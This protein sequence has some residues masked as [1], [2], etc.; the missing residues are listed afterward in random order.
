MIMRF[1]DNF[2]AGG[3]NGEEGDR[4]NEDGEAE[5]V[6]CVDE[7]RCAEDKQKTAA[8]ARKLKRTERATYQKAASLGVM[9]EGGRKK[10]RAWRDDSLTATANTVASIL[11]TA[12]M[13]SPTPA[14][15]G[16]RWTSEVFSP[17][18]RRS[19]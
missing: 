3:Q 4:D 12:S 10:K 14:C 1:R 15:S 19:A 16:R 5:K 9:L 7:G 6:A 2:G 18:A 11:I 13:G 17:P 8:I